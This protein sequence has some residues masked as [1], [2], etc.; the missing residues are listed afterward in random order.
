MANEITGRIVRIGETVQ[1]PSKDRQRTFDRRELTIAEFRFDPRTG[2][3]T[4]SDNKPTL[5]FGG[6]M[7]KELDKYAVGQAVT[8]AFDLQGT[9]YTDRQGET[10]WFTKANG[11]RIRLRPDLMGM[12]QTA[13]SGYAQAAPQPAPQ[14][15]PQQ[16]Q[17]AETAAS[18]QEQTRQQQPAPQQQEMFNSQE[19]GTEDNLPF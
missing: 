12:Q 7:C 17:S 3:R 9:S 16:P 10:K 15:Q 18:T 1:I 8:V 2:E 19:Q 5:E 13:T 4:E 14:A 6:E 11:Y